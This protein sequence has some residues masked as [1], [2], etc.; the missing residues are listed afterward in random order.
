M[1][2]NTSDILVDVMI[3]WGIDTVFGIP[4]DGINGVFEA[5]RQ[6]QDKVRF[7]QTRHE[8]SAA[9]MACAYAKYTGR[10]GCC[11]ATSGPGGIHLLNGLYDAK[12]DQA[13]VLAITGQTYSDLQ[14][15][16][17]QQD[18][19]LVSVFQDVACYNQELL[20][21]AQMSLIAHEACR[22]ALNERGV[23]HLNLPVD[24]QVKEPQ[25]TSM[26]R[27]REDTNSRW[28]PARVV[29]SQAQ[30]TDAA[31]LL[32]ASKR[33]VIMI[34]RGAIG[35][36]DEV[37][38]LAEVLGAPVVKAL[39]GKAAIPDTD[40]RCM[41]GLGLL[42]TRQS[43]VAMEHCD[44][45]LL[46]GT[47]FPYMEFLPKPGHAKGVQ[48][49]DK[50][51]RIG[52]RYPIDVGLVGD[53]KLT[54]S[55][56][57][58]LVQR[59]DDRDFLTG[60]QTLSA[61]WRELLKERARHETPIRPQQIGFEL[62]DLLENDA[63]VSTDSGTNT[64]WAAQYLDMRGDMKFSCSGTLATMACGLPYAIAAKLAFP[65]RQSIAFVGDGGFTML[66]GDFATACKYELPIVVVIVKNN[67]LGQIK[68][69][70]IVFLGNPEYGCDLH[71]IDFARFAE[72]C[73]GVGISVERP[74]DLRPA[75]ERAVASKRPTVVEVLVNPFEPPMPAR[76]TIQQAEHFAEALIKGE[77]NGPQIGLTIFRDK[78]AELL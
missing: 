35:A 46:V 47:S 61:K 22:H 63:I 20:N 50:A 32:N 16:N 62:N 49:D 52:L 30:L 78:V 12:M 39:L 31:E 48:I 33:P 26:H 40:P 38:A 23:A 44:L 25:G 70:Q 45:L 76:V 67:S 19:N 4:G 68:W 65:E 60:L 37:L 75:L 43:E 51:N 72:A 55:A 56:L 13:P 14:G 9:F 53:A 59:K 10:L 29:P 42:G 64:T 2:R 28:N 6:R 21:P 58:P 7:I 11:I 69:E 73:G 36:G 3:E 74:E 77:P 17:F 1:S 24:L 8:E 41:G 54:A 57:L 5:L 18:L 71:P 27:R 34:G 15:T 66:M